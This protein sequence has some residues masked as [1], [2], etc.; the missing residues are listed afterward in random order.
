MKTCNKCHQE[1]PNTEFYKHHGTKDRLRKDCKSCSVKRAHGWQKTHTKQF[2]VHARAAA[3]KYRYGITIEVYNE[4][5]NKQNNCCWICQR[6]ANHFK[7]SL[8]VD[9]LHRPPFTIRGLLC[10]HCNTQLIGR[11]SDPNL[12][13]RAAQYLRQ[14]TG[15]FV[16]EKNH[17][18]TVK[19]R[20]RNKR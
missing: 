5:L 14:D 16:P 4:L 19:R 11:H 9:H 20:H 10:H 13:E 17:K 8:G 12:F 7:R 2:G 3:L 15:L 1:K 6:P 18:R